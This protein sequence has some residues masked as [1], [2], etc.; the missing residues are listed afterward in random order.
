MVRRGL[1][2][3]LQKEYHRQNSLLSLQLE[4]SD[5]YVEVEYIGE[6]GFARVF[7]AKRKQDGKLVAV[8]I[9]N[10]W[11][12]SNGNIFRKLEPHIPCHYISFVYNL[13]L[14]PLPHI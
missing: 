3:K 10:F 1:K 14:N 12:I 11:Q 9:P 8:K 13:H 6:G 4:L 5:S 2:K 7:K